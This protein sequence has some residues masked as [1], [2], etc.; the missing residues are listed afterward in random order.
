MA[1]SIFKIQN[2]Q[3]SL[4]PKNAYSVLKGEFFFRF[5]LNKLWIFHYFEDFVLKNILNRSG[6]STNQDLS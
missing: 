3:N 6:G 1:E 4:I 5:N 2:F